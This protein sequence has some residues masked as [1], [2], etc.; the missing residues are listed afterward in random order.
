LPLLKSSRPVFIEFGEVHSHLT[1]MTKQSL[2]R[3]ALVLFYIAAG[4]NHF[5]QPNFYLPL[6]PPYLPFHGAINIISG[7]IEISFGLLLISTTTRKF[8]A[9]GIVLM[10]IAFIPTHVYFI[11]LNS[12][13]GELCVSPWVGW[14]R[15][16]VI[17]P[18]LLFWAW[19]NR[20]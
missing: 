19:S 2:S 10:L 16:I 7:V 15:L 13:V 4:L 5:I 11:Q 20:K 18:I 6:I 3:W 1:N 8:A 14:V 17:H 12:C 9:Y